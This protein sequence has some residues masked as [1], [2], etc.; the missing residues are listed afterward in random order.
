V[1]LS[2]A[3]PAPFLNPA[4]AFVVPAFRIAG[5]NRGCLV[6]D[7][8]SASADPFALSRCQRAFIGAIPST[9]GEMLVCAARNLC[10]IF[11]FGHNK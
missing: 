6:A 7:T 4:Q 3:Y 11:D 10:R 9:F 2:A 5:I 1:R 8:T